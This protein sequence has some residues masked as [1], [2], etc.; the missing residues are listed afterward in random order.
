MTTADPT[1]SVVVNTVDRAGPLAT[2]LRGL[3]QG[4]VMR[5]LGPYVVSGEWWNKPVHR[6]YHF[7]ETG[8]TVTEEV[9]DRIFSTFC[10]G[11]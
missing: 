5:V 7:A 11:K 6:D 10:I 1:F 2:L 9:L 4:P 8:Q 3:E